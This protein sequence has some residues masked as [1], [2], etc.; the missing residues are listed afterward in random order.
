MIFFLQND[1]IIDLPRRRKQTARYGGHENMDLSD[2]ES[3]DSD[4]DGGK[5]R[6]KS[7]RS[8]KMEEENEEDVDYYTRS[9]CFRVEKMILVFG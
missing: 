9:D 4:D 8:K 5:G 7:R 2:L 1:L 3:S 6:R